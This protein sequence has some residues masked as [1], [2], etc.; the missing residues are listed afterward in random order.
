MQGAAYLLV[1]AA[2][3]M[4][5]VINGLMAFPTNLNLGDTVAGLVLNIAV[6]AAVYVL[7]LAA[8][9][10][11]PYISGILLLIS[12]VIGTMAMPSYFLSGHSLEGNGIA[13]VAFVLLLLFQAV[14]AVLLI[15]SS[16]THHDLIRNQT[17]LVSRS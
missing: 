7:I 15:L 16:R 2:W 11:R 8:G 9:S 4:A 1:I 3:L 6:S 14:A 17:N 12:V 10:K 13:G 5:A